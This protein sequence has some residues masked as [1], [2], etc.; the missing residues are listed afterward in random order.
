VT[1]VDIRDKYNYHIREKGIVE[2]S[3]HVLDVVQNTPN[4]SLIK[5]TFYLYSG[6]SVEIGR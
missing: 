3:G 2:K 6:I 1:I 4:F 5:K